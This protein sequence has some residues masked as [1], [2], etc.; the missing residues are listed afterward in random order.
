MTAVHCVVSGLTLPEG[1]PLARDSL[2]PAAL[3]DGWFRSVYD[4]RTLF[5]DCVHQPDPG[6]Y[7]FTAPAFRNLWPLFRHGLRLNGRPVRGVRRRSSGRCDQVFVPALAPGELAL[8]LGGTLQAI[9]PRQ[10]C[11]GL[12]AGKNAL[13]AINK[14]NDLEWIAEWARYHA[15]VHGANGALIFDNGST[16]Y[17]PEALAETL[18]RT[19][20]LDS[21]AVVSVP[22]P[23]GAKLIAGSTSYHLQFLQ[24]AVINLGRRDFLHR[25][26]AVLSCD[27]DE[28][29]LAPEGGSVFDAAVAAVPGGI[30][31]PGTWVFPESAEAI[32]CAQHHHRFSADPPRPCQPKWCARPDGILSRWGGWNV[33]A[34]GG[35]LR[36]FMPLSTRFRLAHCVG[37][38]TSWKPRSKRFNF[39][40]TLAPL[41]QAA[42]SAG[43]GAQASASP[44]PSA[45]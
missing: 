26:R 32:P 20:L 17:P 38:T 41:P 37:T 43:D 23:Y 3:Q 11:A 9:T 24:T 18:D 44:D 16:Q 10:S 2:V 27:I 36:R 6:G 31:I 40:E 39:P 30:R 28:M 42:L 14:N 4:G 19:G 33:H 1:H 35:G 12:F 22:F 7:L 29:V 5:Y 45:L 15:R 21:V 34:I 25:A 13:M 8:D